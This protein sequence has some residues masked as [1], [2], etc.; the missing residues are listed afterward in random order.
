MTLADIPINR[1]LK[2]KRSAKVGENAKEHVFSEESDNAGPNCQAVNH[3]D[4]HPGEDARCHHLWVGVWVGVVLVP[5]DEVG[6]A[7]RP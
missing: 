6:A 1:D 2:G 7:G 4:E 5:K 3:D